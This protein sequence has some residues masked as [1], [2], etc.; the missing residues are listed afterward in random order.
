M[1]LEDDCVPT[2]A[3]NLSCGPLSITLKD[4]LSLLP[5]PTVVLLVPPLPTIPVTLGLRTPIFHSFSLSLLPPMTILLA[6]PAVN[7]F[8]FGGLPAVAAV[9]LRL[10]C[11]R[12]AEWTGVPLGPETWTEDARLTTERIFIASALVV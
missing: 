4:S 6:C 1:A 3:L 2:T 10:R 8:S 9:G 12:E 11:V 5:S 7:M